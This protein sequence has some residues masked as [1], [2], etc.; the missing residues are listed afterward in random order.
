MNGTPNSCSVDACTRNH[1]AKGYCQLHYNRL[2]NT[3][4][5]DA[6]VRPT[7][8]ELFWS[9]V[10]KTST[11]WLWTAARGEE[12]HALFHVERK[13]IPA[14]RWSWEKLRGPIPEGLVLDHLCRVPWCVNPDHLEPVKNGTNVL[15]GIGPG[16]INKRKTHCIRG[17]EFAGENLRITPG[18]YRNCRACERQKIRD[19]RAAGKRQGIR[20]IK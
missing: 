12:G 2:R 6:R 1:L 13:S 11:C 3:G 7:T 4:T 17:H 8:E 15:R 16:A 14:Y 19:Q 10:S 18:G 9:K 5:T 20:Y